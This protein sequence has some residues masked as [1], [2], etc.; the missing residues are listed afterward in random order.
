MPNPGVETTLATFTLSTKKLHDVVSETRP[1]KCVDVCIATSAHLVEALAPLF[2]EQ[3]NA[4][5]D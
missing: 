3:R 5:F 2:E 4:E 1:R